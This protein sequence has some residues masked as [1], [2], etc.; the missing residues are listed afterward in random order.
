MKILSFQPFSIYQNG[1]GSRILRRIYSGRE[2]Q[3]IS[4][5]I[6]EDACTPV[7]VGEIKEIAIPS[8][9]RNHKWTKWK[10]H[11]VFRWLR[12]DIFYSFT[13]K[14]IIRTVC[15]IPY[16]VIHIVSHGKYAAVLCDDRLL[17]GKK[18]WASFHDHY[19]SAD[20]PF[21]DTQKLWLFSDRRFVISEEMGVKYQNLFGY[22]EYEIVTDGVLKNEITEPEQTDKAK[23]TIYFA[24]LLHIGYYP[25]FESLANALDILCDVH[26]QVCLILRGTQKLPFLSNRK[27]QTEYRASFIIDI[28][29]ELD[30]ADI[31]YFPMKYD[32]VFYLYSI[33][34]KM[35]GY[36]AGAG[37]ILY[38]GPQGSAAHKL[39]EKHNAAV[40][41]FSLNAHDIV[42]SI[43]TII[44]GD[45]NISRNAKKLAEREFLLADM[46]SKF[47]DRQI[48]D[49]FNK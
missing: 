15:N 27:F 40:S 42:N 38:H 14:R 31:L 32:P 5:F 24:G 28:K 30:S 16:D 6:K 11:T 49:Y 17:K 18:L 35:V 7:T 10:L 26:I 9:P 2:N 41:C 47:W 4:I 21:S 33:S 29:K 36:L 48:E 1:G 13:K 45:G 44:N 37:T 3:V 20:T 39:L 23:I 8:F 22:K 34:T 46:Q 43:L 19:L 25:L 12:E